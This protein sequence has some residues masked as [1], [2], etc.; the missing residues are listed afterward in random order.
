MKCLGDPVWVA[1]TPI[2]SVCL[3][4]AANVQQLFQMWAVDHSAKGQS[5]T[6][7]LSVQVALWLWL[8]FYRV[9]TPHAVWAI[10]GTQLGIALNMVVCL[11]VLYWRL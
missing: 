5:L 10:R 11:S 7:W 1:R 4:E 6:A 3:L 2:I 8:N 9:L